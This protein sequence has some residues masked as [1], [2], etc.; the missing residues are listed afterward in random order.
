MSITT[1]PIKKKSVHP[2]VLPTE[3]DQERSCMDI[4]PFKNIP[5][6]L[7]MNIARKTSLAILA[8]AT[9]V[10]L[11]NFRS[12]KPAAAACLELPTELHASI[13]RNGKF[14]DTDKFEKTFVKTEWS[15]L[16][17]PVITE[18]V[19]LALQHQLHVLD[20]TDKD[21]FSKFANLKATHEELRDVIELLINR[22]GTQPNDLH[23]YLEAYQTW[24]DDQQ[25]NVYF[26]GYF[27]PSLKVKKLRDGKYKYP[28]Y[29]FPEN[30]KGKLP[31]RRDIDEKG[32]L[33]TMNLVLAYATNPL[34]I[35]FMQLQGSGTIE[36]VDTKERTLLRYAGENGHRYR[37]IQHFFKGR[38]DL[39]L[40]NLTQE[41]I[42]RFLLKNPE[43]VDSVLFYDPSYTF[44][45][46]KK[47]LAKGAGNVPLMSEISI[48][49]DPRYFPLGSVVLAAVPVYHNGRITHHEYKILLPQDKGGAIKGAGHVD[50][51]CG[52]GQLG[53][54]RASGLHHFGKMWVLLPKKNEQV[55]MLK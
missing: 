47:G 35:Y 23:Q 1:Q 4:G 27:T 45:E 13:E 17:L 26:T 36:Y 33:D 25:G 48:A 54:S 15:A 20:K 29:A 52:N 19:K 53:Q 51:Y 31:S 14:K 16:G 21:G 5:S 39:K 37:N 43:K 11:L 28:I 46:P 2:S 30:W 18:E 34:D 10:L 41:G 40:T 32:V 55:A 3:D 12:E 6:Y 22:A 8:A 9:C 50:V 44:F 38:D 49:A 42:R 7:P 24:G